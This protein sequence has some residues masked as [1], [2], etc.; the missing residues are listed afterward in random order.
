MIPIREWAGIF[1][2]A[3][4][5][6]ARRFLLFRFY[7]DESYDGKA[8]NPDY[9]T[10][11]GFFADQPTWEEVEEEWDAINR[12]Y[13]ILEFHATK[14][15]RRVGQY[16]GWCRD[17][18]CE[19]SAELL[20]VI[21]RQKMR[22]VA[23]NCGI[24][25]D[26][27]RNV[28]SNVGQMKLG[29]PWI[30]CFQSCIAMVAKH[31]ETLPESDCFSVVFGQESRFEG[32]AVSA[33]SQMAANPLFEYRHRLMTC[34]SGSPEKIIPLQVADLMAYEYYKRICQHGQRTPVPELRVPL[35]LIQDNNNYCEGIFGDPWFLANKSM[36]EAMVCGQ[37]QLVVIPNLG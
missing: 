21:T 23:Y 17:K 26:A 24:R 7:C 27:Y 36:I 8:S 31:M 10:M 19:Y 9:F 5:R 35:R 22:M 14:L 20:H 18:A 16:E 3:R 1:H 37:N 11:S 13:G 6:N 29:H 2:P 30:M 32:M 28:I 33:F 25:G 15:N 34:T 12:R 4:S